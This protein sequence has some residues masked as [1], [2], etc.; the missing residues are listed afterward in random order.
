MNE[1][2]LALNMN[3]A[4]P[5]FDSLFLEYF[6][7]VFSYVHRL[8]GEVPAAHRLS[9]EAFD[10][11]ARYYRKSRTPNHPRTLLYLLASARA[12]DYLR[13]GDRQPWWQRLLRSPREPTVE[14]S[15]AEVSG[16][17]SDT[18]QRALGTLEFSARMVLLLHDYC[19]LSYDE[20]AR[21]A[22]IGRTSVPRDL[23][24]ARHDFKQAYDYIRF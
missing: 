5:D 6:N 12:R 3:S 22:A 20:V 17:T 23:D 13:K 19:G 7:Q 21:A 14:F 15:E 1:I 16:L 24:R 10:E 8:V 2:S 9:E 4:E 11:M 18:G